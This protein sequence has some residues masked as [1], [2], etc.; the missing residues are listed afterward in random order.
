VA[1][2][3]PQF[4]IYA[5]ILTN[6]SNINTK[7]LKGF[8]E[9]LPAEQIVFN[10]MLETIRKTYEL[11]GF[12]PVDTPIL[13]SAETLLAKAGGE[14]EQQ[15]YQ[16]T[17]GKT[18][19]AMR[20]D[21]TV[22]LARYV[23][24]HERE[25]AFPFR[26]YAIGKVYR[27]ERPQ[28]GRLRE[29][30][31]CDIDIIGNGALPLSAD[32]E[33]P[34]V[35]NDIFTS[36]LPTGTKFTIRINNR[37]VL[38]SFFDYLDVDQVTTMR[39]LDKL[40]K[41]GPEG[42][43]SELV[44]IGVEQDKIEQIL[45]FAQISGT[46]EQILAKL[47]E[48]N[49]DTTELRAVVSDL[50]QIDLSIARGLDY[51]TGTVYETTLDDYPQVGSVCSGGRYDNL[52]STYTNSILPGVG[53]SIGISRLFDQLRALD[54]LEF[55]SSTPTSVLILSD[56]TQISTELA[57]ELRDNSI[58]TEIQ[59]LGKLDKQLKY[60][61]KLGIQYVII[62]GDNELKQGKYTLKDMQT[63]KQ[64]LLDKEEITDTL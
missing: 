37:K 41:I 30:Y 20:F 64:Q 16:F 18:D 11:Y 28:A 15:I 1:T 32:A 2:I 39:I 27:G 58:P 50:V 4:L 17:K 51:Y 36:I 62:I 47:N 29:F 35:I 54:L 6:M 45:S 21:L 56:S 19:Y 42:V 40:D 33:L 12:I 53:V 63:G 3:L 61:N 5:N 9:L 8:K 57:S 23:A 52:A 22:P 34:N 38:N 10:N 44:S 59:G 25:L 43:G 24:E 46:N 31:Q 7:T 55:D 13:E 14:T 49:I 60:A 26:R 48:M